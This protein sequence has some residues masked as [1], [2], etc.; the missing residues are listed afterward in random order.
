MKTTT[1][2][3]SLKKASYLGEYKLKLNF[4]DNHTNTIDFE[5]FLMDAR[6]PMITKY[7]DKELFQNFKIE[8]SDLMWNDFEMSFALEDIYD[9]KEM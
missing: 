3:L 1:L 5:K 4:S 9:R 6:N 8:D 2:T 7:R